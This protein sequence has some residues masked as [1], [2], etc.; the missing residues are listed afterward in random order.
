VIC[1]AW[2]VPPSATA[3]TAIGDAVPTLIMRG[4]IDPFS[5]PPADLTDAIGSATDVHELDVPNASYNVLSFDCP[6]AIRDAWMDS[7]SAPPADTS[8][9]AQMPPLPLGQ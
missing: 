7:P 6:R 2:A 5:A 8:C 4:S 9:L 1:V 3:G